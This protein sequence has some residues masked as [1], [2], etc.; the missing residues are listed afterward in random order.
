MLAAAMRGQRAA[1]AAAARASAAAVAIAAT[2]AGAGA[3]VGAGASP[4][5]GRGRGAAGDVSPTVSRSDGTLPR[6]YDVV[7]V[8]KSPCGSGY[9][10][11]LDG[12]TL[13]TPGR[14]PLTMPTESLAYAVAAEWQWQDTRTV[15]PL[16]MPMMTLAATAID[17]MPD[18]RHAVI[19]KLLE[20]FSGDPVVCRA[21][22]QAHSKDLPAKQAAAFDPIARWLSEDV[23]EGRN[24]QVCARHG[25]ARGPSAQLLALSAPER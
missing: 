4:D 17:I 6:A 18:Q 12:K 25:S 22:P 21:P 5:V 2:G 23:L 13:R 1:A 19:G 11:T 9:G 3:G 14:N 10:I 24:L 15:Q 7:G 16:T 8:V 20:Y